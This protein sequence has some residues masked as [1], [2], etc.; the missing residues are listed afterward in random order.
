MGLFRLYILFYPDG[1]THPLML[2][3]LF[4]GVVLL[5]LVS[6]FFRWPG[7]IQPGGVVLSIILFNTPVETYVA[8]SLNRIFDTGVGVLIALLINLLLPRERVYKVM[9]AF[10][11]GKHESNAMTAQSSTDLELSQ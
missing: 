11:P 3:F 6:Q 7:A 9:D 10:K 4:I 2:L 1:S 8:Y 5:I